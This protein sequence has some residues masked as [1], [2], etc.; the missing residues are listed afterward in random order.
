MT[1]DSTTSTTGTTYTAAGDR[2]P[3]KTLGQEDFLK[4]ITVQLAKQDPL[5]PMDDTSFMAQMAQFSALEQSSQ[6]AT[7]MAALRSDSALQSAAGMIGREVTLGT[8]DGPVTGMVDYV[9]TSSG[10]VQISVGGV[11]YP[12]SQVTRVAAAPI[13]PQSQS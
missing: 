1:I 6:M 9:D 10:E 4:L 12:L 3:K 7:D 13:T 2:I 11:L 8:D 5:K